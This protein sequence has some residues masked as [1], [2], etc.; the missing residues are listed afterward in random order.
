M[1]IIG[2]ARSASSMTCS[3]IVRKGLST[4]SDL[5]RIW[6]K[7]MPSSIHVER[8]VNNISE[9]GVLHGQTRD[10]FTFE[11]RRLSLETSGTKR[12]PPG[13]LLLD[14]SSKPS[15]MV[16]STAAGRDIALKS[17]LRVET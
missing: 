13:P 3:S 11:Q 12:V 1:M 16:L 7:F 8:I 9:Q 4:V 5:A 2:P 6:E 17:G 10:T 15:C 14:I